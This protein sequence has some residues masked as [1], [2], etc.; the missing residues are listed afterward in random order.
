ML[1]PKKSV[2]QQLQSSWLRSFPSTVYTCIHMCTSV[3]IQGNRLLEIFIHYTHFLQVCAATHLLYVCVSQTFRLHLRMR[4]Q[5]NAGEDI[6]SFFL[7]TVISYEVKCSSICTLV[8]K[9]T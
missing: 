3:L 2:A 8:M 5:Q 1:G 9:H 7:R 4:P 6:L